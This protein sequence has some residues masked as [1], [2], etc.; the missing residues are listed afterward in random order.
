[1]NSM[2]IQL[3][4][5]SREKGALRPC[6]SRLLQLP[7][8]PQANTCPKNYN[9]NRLTHP[10][11]SKPAARGGS[12]N[13]RCRCSRKRTKDCCLQLSSPGLCTPVEP[14]SPY[15][16]VRPV[17]NP[18]PENNHQA[19]KKAESPTNVCSSSKTHPLP[20]TVTKHQRS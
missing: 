12:H 14:E 7:K 13:R 19:S 17:D 9:S 20:E 11:G 1:M 6:C 10:K 3:P 18:P 4:R 5:D 16:A 15:R 8:Y 2:N